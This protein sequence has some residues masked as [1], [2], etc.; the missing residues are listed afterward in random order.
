[1]NRILVR[2][3]A[4]ILLVLSPV[5]VAGAEPV[6]SRL[7]FSSGREV[8]GEIVLRNDEVVIVKDSYGTRFQFPVADIVEIVELKE[9]EPE[10]KQQDEKTSRT[11]R[12][13]KRT[14]L[15]VHLAGGVLTLDGSLGGA[16]AADVRLGA[17]NL[18][19]RRIFLGGQVGYRAL[20]AESRT[21]SLIPIDAV[22]ELPLLQGTH[23]PMIGATVG[24]GIGLGSVRGGLNGGLS[25]CYRYHFSRTGSLSIGVEAEVLQLSSINNSIIVEPGQ[26][27]TSSEGRTAVT[28][29]FTMGVLF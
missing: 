29:M 17:N 7:L 20:M 10:Q 13:V 18:G 1:M 28:G 27:F 24:Y 21:I 14:S 6:L 2:I 12:N 22:L 5:L 11:V 15:G 9:D 25:L 3:L 4:L 23:V 26:T 8:V 16:L 19:G